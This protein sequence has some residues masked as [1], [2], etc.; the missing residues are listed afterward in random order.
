MSQGDVARLLGWSL[1]KMQRI[2]GGEV[3]VSPTDLHALLDVYGV[4]DDDQVRQLTNDAHASR[5]QRYVTAPDHRAH[6]SPGLLELMQFEKLAVSIRAYQP[7]F[8]PGVLQTPTVAEAILAHWHDSLSEEARRVRYDVRMSRRRQVIERA[9]GPE[10]CLILDESVIKR[11]I[12]DAKVTAEQLEVVAGLSLEPNVHIRI[13]PFAKGAYM[14]A[15]GAFQILSV[16]NERNDDVLYREAFL[17]DEMTHD[18]DEVS[19]HRAAFE[20]IWKQSRSEEA[21]YRMLVAEASA[22]RSLVDQDDIV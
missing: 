3:G 8:Y 21:T 6:L 2:E 9:G 14:P 16:S 22:L 12:L 4:T 5:R 20:D 7:V 17:R 13:V 1:S 18:P 10:Y 11:R 15:L 19:F